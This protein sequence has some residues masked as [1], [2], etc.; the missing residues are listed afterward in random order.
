MPKTII[1]PLDGS[2]QATT[3]IPMASWLAERFGADLHL[4]TATAGDDSGRERSTLEHA[5][6]LTHAGSPH[7]TVISGLRPADAIIETTDAAPDSVVCMSTRGHGAT[8]SMLFGG[9]AHD[10]IRGVTG[11]VVL[12]GPRHRD[13]LD[14][15]QDM[16]VCVTRPEER[17]ALLELA[18]EWSR[19]LGLRLHV[20]QV[21]DRG[22]RP[23]ADLVLD[24]VKLGLTVN[25][26]RGTMEPDDVTVGLAH[27]LDAA[28]VVVGTDGENRPADEPTGHIASD[29]VRTCHCPVLVQ[30][31]DVPRR[32]DDAT[33]DAPDQ[34]SWRSTP[35][36]AT[37]SRTAVTP[38]VTTADLV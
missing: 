9:V 22:E 6:R 15:P 33:G 4:V 30:R 10:V 27:G 31:T 8:G 3:A 29:I 24:D 11:P 18:A 21:L 25:V 19:A 17:D 36:A 2:D 35:R 14:D 28:L 38:T 34:S 7:T 26:R 32:D 5:A 13:E 1:V 12:V 23:P 20:V 37:M 16:I